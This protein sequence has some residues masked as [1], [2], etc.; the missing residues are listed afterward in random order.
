MLELW[1]A[2]FVWFSLALL[3]SLI[4]LRLGI[5]AVLAELIVG[6]IVGNLFYIPLTEWINLLANFGAVVIAFLAGAELESNA[7]RNYWKSSLIIGIVAFLPALIGTGLLAYFLLGWNIKQSI[8]AGTALSSISIAIVYALL[9][10]TNLNEKPIGKLLLSASFINGLGTLLILT[11]LFVKVDK[12]FWIFLFITIILFI[13]LP[14]FTRAY[15]FYVR[16]HPSEPE[17]KFIFLLLAFLGFLASYSGSVAVLPA[18]LIGVSLADVFAKNRELTRRTRIS[19]IALLTPFY[20]LKAGSLIDINAIITSLGFIILFFMIRAILKLSSL[21]I[22]GFFLKFPK[23]INLFI[24]MMMTTG[25]TFDTIVALYGLEHKIISKE[26]YSL[27]EAV[28][29]LSA[30]IPTFIA[31]KFLF[32]REGDNV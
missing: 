19:S 8:L 3:S 18:Y 16:N 17:V 26:Q 10:E 30:V 13:L 2:I 5:S 14:P 22:V 1:W 23:R 29:L 11:I 6:I 32:P 9:I 24:A 20:F 25:L 31:Q 21:S 4:S 7:I 28:V 27:L 15:F 12:T